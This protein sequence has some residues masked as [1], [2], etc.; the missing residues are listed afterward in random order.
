V[1]VSTIPSSK[2]SARALA[3]AVAAGA[4]ALAAPHIAEAAPFL[5]VGLW[6]RVQGS[7]AAFSEFVVAA[8]G[9]I[10][11]YE[12]RAQLGAEDSVNPYA[13]AT[14]AATTT[15]ISNWVPSNGSTTPTSGLNQVR[16]HIISDGAAIFTS[17]ATPASGWADAPG[18]SPGTPNGDRLDGVNLIRAAGNFAGIAPDGNPQVLTLATGVYEVAGFGG[19]FNPVR[20]AIAGGGFTT[21]TVLATMRFRNDANS[22]NVN[23][24]PTVLQQTNSTTGAAQ[25]GNIIDP[26]IVYGVPEP[27]ALGIIA[28]GALA[29]RRR[30]R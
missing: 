10:V 15:T 1:H 11:E 8:P 26:I 6:G 22:A 13:G 25:G 18:N 16:F 12:I 5:T 9:E 28:L 30:R 20:P 23:Y 19:L 7:G 2:K 21:T 24:N 14:A 29:C 27:G 4:A 3:F 17:G